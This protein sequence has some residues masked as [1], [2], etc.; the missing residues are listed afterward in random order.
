MLRVLAACEQFLLVPKG[1]LDVVEAGR[2][3]VW[4]L[5][6]ATSCPAPTHMLAPQLDSA[7]G[8]LSCVQ[9]YLLRPDFARLRSHLRVASQTSRSSWDNASEDA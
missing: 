4:P 7:K 2:E 1:S 8:L 6:L 9:R 3:V 5:D